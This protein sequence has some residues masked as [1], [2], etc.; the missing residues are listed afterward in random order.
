MNAA[1]LVFPILILSHSHS[2]DATLKRLAGITSFFVLGTMPSPLPKRVLRRSPRRTA[3]EPTASP[4][5]I[6]YF[7]PAPPNACPKSLANPQT[8]RRKPL[9]ARQ[10]KEIHARSAHRTQLVK[11]LTSDTE[12][13][14]HR[15]RDMFGTVLELMADL[16]ERPVAAE[17]GFAMI[18]QQMITLERSRKLR[19]MLRVARRREARYQAKQKAREAKRGLS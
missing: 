10:A 3:N 4:R 5:S 19:A 18:L 15:C 8:R 7:R 13:Q 14:S 12:K 9:P 11:S 2:H 16:S 17:E 6:L 1:A